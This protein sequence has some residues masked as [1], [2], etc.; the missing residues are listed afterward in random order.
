MATYTISDYD[1]LQAMSS[2]RGDDCVLAND[3]DRD[4]LQ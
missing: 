3:I 4:G 1:E 2:H